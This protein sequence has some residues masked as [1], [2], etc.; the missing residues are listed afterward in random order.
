LDPSHR[1]WESDLVDKKKCPGTIE[2]CLEQVKVKYEAY[3]KGLAQAFTQCKQS[4]GSNPITPPLQILSEITFLLATAISLN[5][6]AKKLKGGVLDYSLHLKLGLHLEE[7]MLAKYLF[8]EQ[9]VQ[10]KVAANE[11]TAANE[12]FMNDEFNGL[13]MTLGVGPS[14]SNGAKLQ[15][16]E[17]E[18]HRLLS[19]GLSDQVISFSIQACN[20]S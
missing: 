4:F 11:N 10:K 6:E 15:A 16:V 17:Q 18:Y 13:L 19:Q 3:R 5:T 9:T 8:P 20:P 1:S 2:A 7:V 12:S 14:A